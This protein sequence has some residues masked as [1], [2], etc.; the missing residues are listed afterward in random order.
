M[1]RGGF[2]VSKLPEKR[3]ERIKLLV[4]AIKA[5]DRS[6]VE[7]I[8][9][10]DGSLASARTE[11]G[12]TP[13]HVAV[14]SHR[15]DITQLL[16]DHGADI[17]VKF[18]GSGHTPLSWAVTVGAMDVANLLVRRGAPL[19]LWCAAGMG[20]LDAV[21]SFW[22]GNRQLRPGASQRARRATIATASRSIARRRTRATSFPMPFTS[23]RATAN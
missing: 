7:Q 9:R 5:G 13:L 1:K 22:N 3:A 6:Q 15:A 2:D 17:G 20:N 16:L 10:E 18:G 23:P 4:K 19:D 8:L 21:K 12:G 11:H 14:E